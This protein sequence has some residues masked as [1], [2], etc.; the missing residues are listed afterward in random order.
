MGDP[1]A[2][3]AAP[4]RSRAG[5]L[6]AVLLVATLAA[7]YGG[8]NAWREDR[9]RRRPMDLDGWGTLVTRLKA[10]DRAATLFSAPSL[11]KGPV[12]P[13]VFGLAYYLAP[14]DWSVLVFNVAAFAAAAACFYLGFCAFGLSR[15]GALLAVLF[16][17]FYWPHHYVFGYYYAEPFLALLLA[18]LLLLTR[19]ALSGRRPYT[20]LLTGAVSGLLLLARAPFLFCVCGL[21][22]FLWCHAGARS[23]RLVAACWV[24]GFCLAFFPWGVRNFLTYGEMVPFTTEG[25]KILFQGTYLPGDSATMNEIRQIPEFAALEKAEGTGAIEQYRYWRPLAVRQALQDPLGQA[26]LCVRKA[27]R[28]WVYLPQHS[29]VPSWKTAALAALVL[30]L[31]LAAVVLGR[32]RPLV[33]LCALWV[34]RP[35]GV[36][37]QLHGPA[38]AGGAG[39]GRGR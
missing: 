13:F 23:R 39:R 9:Q 28:F 29:W 2:R 25:G 1:G 21:L 18:L 38:H 6:G 16:W 7:L 17:V 19:R 35:H 8:W 20:A 37:L 27:I 24:A 30:P 3:G 26:R 31:A 14:S 22:V 11:W 10:D 32:R 36:A 34:A 5:Q 4:A 15:P 12:V 33:Q